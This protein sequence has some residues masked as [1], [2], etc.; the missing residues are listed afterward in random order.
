M[1]KA[2]TSKQDRRGNRINKVENEVK[3]P[4]DMFTSFLTKSANTFPRREMGDREKTMH[5]MGEIEEL[6]INEECA[7]ASQS[8]IAELRNSEIAGGSGESKIF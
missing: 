6:N 4:N 2:Q 8:V 5:G 3:S 7:I 1:G